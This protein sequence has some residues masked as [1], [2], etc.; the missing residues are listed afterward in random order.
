MNYEQKSNLYQS[1]LFGGG[2][3]AAAAI[4]ADM[5]RSHKRKAD[6][7]NMKQDKALTLYM[8]SPSDQKVASDENLKEAGLSHMIVASLLAGGTFYGANAL[9]TKMRKEQLKKEVEEESQQYINAL[10]QPQQPMK[11]AAGMFENL[12]DIP[13]SILLLS[14][15]AGG[16]GTYGVLENTFPKV[17]E[18]PAPGTPRKVVVKNFGTLFTDDRTGQGIADRDKKVVKQEL[19]KNDTDREEDSKDPTQTAVAPPASDR[20]FRFGQADH[21]KAAAYTALICAKREMEN[22]PLAQ[23]MG[24]IIQDKSASLMVR[25]LEHMDFLGL[26][27][28]AKGCETAYKSA[29]EGRRVAAALTLFGNPMLKAS[30][31]TLLVGEMHDFNPGLSKI[32]RS[33]ADD[34]SLSIVATKLASALLQ[35]TVPP[36]DY[37]EM[38]GEQMPDDFYDEDIVESEGAAELADASEHEGPDPVDEAVDVLAPTMEGQEKPAEE[39]QID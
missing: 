5:L 25:D 24:R 12:A 16:A 9:Y 6:A 33:V 4:L 22:N 18:K 27:S 26:I 30:A 35:G 7:K 37:S 10:S 39:D 21:Q 19:E 28:S 20:W 31:A 2:S 36:P 11:T 13:R 23:L 29:S 1:A 32:A 14:F 15:L 38:E 17:S 3:I 34:Y 8:P